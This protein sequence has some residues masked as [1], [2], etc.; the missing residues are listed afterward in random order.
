MIISDLPLKCFYYISTR[1]KRKEKEE[2]EEEQGSPLSRVF[3]SER[4]YSGYR[5]TTAQS[6]ELLAK[7][8]GVFVVCLLCTAHWANLIKM[9]TDDCRIIFNFMFYIH[10]VAQVE[11]FA[12][13]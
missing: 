1:K 2:E 11:N 3:M 13:S 12:F 5:T 9:L 6:I 8:H 10:G 7:R 4:K